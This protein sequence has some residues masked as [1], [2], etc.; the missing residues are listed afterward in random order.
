MKAVITMSDL[1]CQSIIRQDTMSDVTG[2]IM[3]L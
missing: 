3:V 1:P 2:C